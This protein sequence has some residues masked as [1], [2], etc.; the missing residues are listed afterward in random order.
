MTPPKR[1]VF[2]GSGDF[3]VPVLAALAEHPLADLRAVVTAA[4]RPA[5]RR[6]DLQPTPVGRWAADHGLATLTPAR[7]RSAEALAEV[8][9]LEPELIVLA[10]YGQLVPAELLRLPAHGALNLHPSLLPRW[11]G[12][13]PIPAAILA[14]DEETGVTLMLMDD[15]LDSGPIV[16]QEGVRLTGSET[17]PELE[18]QLASLAA[19]VLNE[20]L[21]A[22]LAGLIEPVGQNEAAVTM[23]RPL[24]RSDG[25]LDALLPASQLE[26]QVRAYQP[27][28]GSYLETGEGRIVVWSAAVE[29]A[30]AAGEPGTLIVADDGSPALITAQGLLVLREVQPAGGRRMS[31]HELLRGRPALAALKGSRG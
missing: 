13:A 26:R 29:A 2:L 4:P 25:L 18:R 5:G 23:T 30:S 22:W 24:R 11:R 15:G 31:G 21:R 28:P 14:G 19:V 6:Q 8:A 3:A 7:L 1:T 9:A 27:W 12:A 17:A 20:S 10:D 16:A